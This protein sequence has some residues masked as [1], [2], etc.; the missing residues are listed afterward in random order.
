[1]S[2]L[3]VCLC[4][5]F[6]PCF[7]SNIPLMRVVQ[8]VKQ[9]KRRSSGILK[10]GWLLHHTNADTLVSEHQDALVQHTGSKIVSIFRQLCVVNVR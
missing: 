2:L 1:M 7:S 9:S 5:S 4:L 6:S 8:S 10:R 3:F